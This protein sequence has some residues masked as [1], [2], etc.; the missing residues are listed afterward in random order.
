M[1]EYELLYIVSPRVAVDDVP[2]AIERVNALVQGVGGEV[3]AVDNW[4]RR[5]MAYPIQHFFEGTYVLI[6]M[7][8]D[9]ASAAPLEASLI[10][11]AEILRHLLTEGII[12][13]VQRERP[14][15]GDDRERGRFGEDRDRDRDRPPAMSEERSA[16]MESAVAVAEPP[17]VTEAP[18][19]AEAPAVSEPA[20]TTE[21][22]A[23]PAD[24]PADA[25]PEPA[26]TAAE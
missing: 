7:R 26:P 3:T 21:A 5:R 1:R 25:T 12:P 2:S 9:P 14:R 6:A 16:P 24:A 4:G 20:A 13:Q 11:S 10:L 18:A 8:L 17:A 22:V 19:V 15:F 23:E